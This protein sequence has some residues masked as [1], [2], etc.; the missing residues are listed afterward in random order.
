MR[1][2]QHMR[3]N[4][5]TASSPGVLAVC[6][7]LLLIPAHG[8][9]AVLQ[10]AESISPADSSQDASS[11]GGSTQAAAVSTPSQPLSPAAAQALIDDLSA[12]TFTQRQSAARALRP[13]ITQPELLRVISAALQAETQPE[14]IRRLVELLEESFRTSDYRSAAAALTAETLEQAAASDKWYLSEAAQKV[15]ERLWRRRV[16]VAVLEL[17]RL[18]VPLEPTDPQELWRM[19]DSRQPLPGGQ[20]SRQPMRIYIDEH[21]PADPRAFALLGRLRGLGNSQVIGGGLISIYRLEGHPL[22]VEQTAVLKGIFGDFRVQDRGRVCLGV[23][24]DTMGASTGVR[25]GAVQPGSSADKA[26]LKAGDFVSSLNGI[27]L[28]GFEEL[29]TLLRDYKVGDKVTLRISPLPSDENQMFRNPGGRIIPGLPGGRGLPAPPLP[30][31]IPKKE[32]PAPGGELGKTPGDSPKIAPDG[33]RDM[34]VVLQGWYDRAS[35]MR[36]ADDEN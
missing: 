27:P 31:E 15:L 3:S 6:V 20:A 4:C 16:E 18:R 24:S 35:L 22:T 33:S 7:C 29:V 34:E 12:A 11:E 17:R 36:P 5:F 9:A 1:I 13:H 28:S 23:T 2:R 8:A 32:D 30:R 10:T 25:I 21:W 26:G 19:A 14:R